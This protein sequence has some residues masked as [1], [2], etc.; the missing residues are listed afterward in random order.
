METCL[1][2]QFHNTMMFPLFFYRVGKDIHFLR[3]ATI[4]QADRKKLA[5]AINYLVDFANSWKDRWKYLD[6]LFLM[7]KFLKNFVFIFNICIVLYLNSHWQ[8][9]Q[10]GHTQKGHLSP[11]C[12]GENSSTAPIT[13]VIFIA[14]SRQLLCPCRIDLEWRCQLTAAE[15]CQQGIQ[16]FQ[17]GSRR[18]VP[19]ASRSTY[20]QNMC[21]L[22]RRHPYWSST[23]MTTEVDTDCM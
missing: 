20:L 11:R 6:S 13:G 12:C 15:S 8:K 23:A 18:L 2:M 3:A 1:I 5:C 16:V 22:A 19:S 17:L 9:F 4:C 10:T 7:S 21:G 14:L